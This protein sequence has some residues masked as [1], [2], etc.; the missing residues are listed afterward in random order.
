VVVGDAARALGL[1]DG[2]VHAE[3]RV[4]ADDGEHSDVWFL[5]LAARTIGGLCARTLRFGA[6]VSL[7]EL[8]LRHALGM[9][10]DDVRPAS[11]ASGVL[12]VPIPRAGVLREVRGVDE[13]RAVP[14]VA[15]VEMTITRGR[16]VRPLP[17]GDRYLG[18]VF[19]RGDTPGA[20]EDALRE[21]QR[22]LEVVID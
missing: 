5:E 16:T 2:P 6:G 8:V 20:V 1:R 21:A 19:A 10:V 22:R 4:D 11:S 17:E 9:P 13:A 3:L 15:G 7:E 12:M 14:G 18:F